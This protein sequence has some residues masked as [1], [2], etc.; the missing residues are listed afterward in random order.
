M[1]KNELEIFAKIDGIGS[2]SGLFLRENLLYV[3]GDNSAYLYE[4][5]IAEK[6]LSKIELLS[7][8]KPSENIAKSLKPDFEVLC[9]FRDQL[10]ILGSGSKPNRNLMLCYNLETKNVTRHD[11]TFLYS[12]IKKSTGIDEENFNIE[13]AVPTETDWY[14]F[15][16][17]NGDANKNGVFKIKGTDLVKASSVTFIPI[18]LLKTNNVL[19]SFTDAVQ[20]LNHIYFIAAAEN[21]TSTYDDGEILGSYIGK[22]DLENFRLDFTKKISAHQKFEGITFLKQI[23]EKLEFLLCEDKDND[24]LE[25]VIYKVV[26]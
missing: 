8:F 5:N 20:H 15:N 13:G 3:I 14:L 16:R 4:Y 1:D 17:G 6:E 9:H 18:A 7:G 23:D 24:I 12:K 10:F 11:L 21:T 19:V 2:A 25:T 26:L 22:I